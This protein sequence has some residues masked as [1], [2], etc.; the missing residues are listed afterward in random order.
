M[1]E[2]IKIAAL[3]SYHRLVAISDQITTAL[4]ILIASTEDDTLVVLPK[5]TVMGIIKVMRGQVDISNK[6]VEHQSEMD[7]QL[8]DILSKFKK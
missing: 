2:N 3:E 6:L 8:A 5:E 4:E 1:E 7:D